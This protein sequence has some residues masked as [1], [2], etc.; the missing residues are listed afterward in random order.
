MKSENISAVSDVGNTIWHTDEVKGKA[1]VI[2]ASNRYAF[3]DLAGE[4]I[5]AVVLDFE[6]YMPWG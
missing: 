4:G 2:L 6:Q 5:D 3:N 1:D